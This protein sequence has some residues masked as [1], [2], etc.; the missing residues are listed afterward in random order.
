M[1]L[2][3][4]R[5]DRPGRLDRPAPQ[6]QSVLADLKGRKDPKDLSERKV[7]QETGARPVLLAPKVRSVPKARKV[8]RGRKGQQVLPVLVANPGRKAPPDHLAPRVSPEPGQIPVPRRRFVSSRGR[9][10]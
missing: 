10:R 1:S 6:G 8:N 5:K 7:H 3:Q 9:V 2:L 4:V